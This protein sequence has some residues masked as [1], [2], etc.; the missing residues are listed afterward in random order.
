MCTMGSQ[1]R[2]K[3]QQQR[4]GTGGGLVCF[5]LF[6]SFFLD[7]TVALAPGPLNE[8]RAALPCKT[9]QQKK[10][11]IAASL[12][13]FSARPLSLSLFFLIW[14]W[15][16]AHRTDRGRT[17]S[18]AFLSCLDRTP[19]SGLHFRFCHSF[20]S[21]FMPA[22]DTPAPTQASLSLLLRSSNSR[23]LARICSLLLP[24]SLTETFSLCA[25]PQQTK[26]HHLSLLSNFVLNSSDRLGRAG[27]AGWIDT[28]GLPLHKQ[29]EQ[30]ES[31]FEHQGGHHI[32]GKD[33]RRFAGQCPARSREDAGWDTFGKWRA[34]H[35]QHHQ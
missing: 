15:A 12:L 32:V 28:L 16:W 35:S 13:D 33:S 31:R 17:L 34:C 7:S 25:W 9:T 23:P 2:E 5:L 8:L 6:M 4:L 24:H 26:F 22:P 21:V 20:A 10:N 3:R 14:A 11:S 1:T 18:H 30:S 27:A 29:L 19:V